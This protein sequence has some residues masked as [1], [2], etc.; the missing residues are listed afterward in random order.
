MQF[1]FRIWN[2]P[3]TGASFGR[4]NLCLQCGSVQIRASSPEQHNFVKEEVPEFKLMGK[5]SRHVWNGE[6]AVSSA[7]DGQLKEELEFI[8]DHSF[9]GIFVWNS[10]GLTPGHTVEFKTPVFRLG[11]NQ[12]REFSYLIR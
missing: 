10:H 7:L 6:K 5:V 3:Q 4:K 1:G 8:P 11:P 9:A 2:F 12:S